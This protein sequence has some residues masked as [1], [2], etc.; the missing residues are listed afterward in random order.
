[1]M[2]QDKQFIVPLGPFNDKVDSHDLRREWEEWHRAFELILQMGK[3]KS[4]SRKLVSMLAMGGRGLQRIYYNLRAVP[5]EV[6]P[7]PIKVPMMPTEIPEYDNAVKRLQHFF[8]GK[9]NE[10][11]DLEVFRSLR[12]LPEE[13]FNTFML[14]LR[15]QAARCEFSEREEKELLQ[16]ITIGAREEKV[17]DKA[18]ENIMNLDEIIIYAMNRE[19]LLQQ[20]EKHKPFS[21]GTEVNS[22]NPS[23]SRNRNFSSSR[24]IERYQRYG[25][26][27][28]DNL[29]NGRYYGA[30]V[31]GCKRCG[32]SR[33]FEDSRDCVARN[34]RCN[35]CGGHGHYAR[36][37]DNRVKQTNRFFGRD[38]NRE[39][40][41]E[42]SR[43]LKS[44]T[45]TVDVAVT[46]EEKDHIA[47]V[48]AINYN[49]DSVLC[50]IDDV[51][52]EFIIDSGS[53]INA[54]TE[55]VWHK[56]ISH[57]AKIFKRK[58]QCDRKF[59]AYANSE[60]LMVTAIFEAL[61]SVNPTKPTNYAEFFVIKGAGKCLLSKRTSEDLKL[62]R[63]GL[64]VLQVNP[65]LGKDT[66][67]FPK[68]PGVQVKLS[69]DPN[70]PPKKIAY[71]RIPAAMEQKVDNKIKEMLQSDVIEK[72][73]GPAD[74]ISPMV[75]VPKGKDDIRICI[76]MKHP[77]E[78]IQ[79]EHYPLPIIDTFLNK[80]K[81]SKFYSRLDITSAYHHVELHPDSRG[82]TTFMTNMG[83]MRF[84]R[85][86][87]GINCA[88]EIFQRIMTDM[89]SG[90]DGVIVY[91]DDIV[92]SGSNREE[93]DKRLQQVL[94]VL[95][96]NNAM[97]NR[98]KFVF[99]VEKL[100]ILGFE[101]SAQGISPSEEK[102][103]AIKNFR[104]PSSK[105]EVRSFLGLLNFVGHFIP[106][107]STRT[108]PLRKFI[109]GEVEMF[110]REQMDAFDDLRLELSNNVRELGFYDPLDATAVYVDASPVG[111]GAVLTQTDRHTNKPRI[112]CFA[113]KGLTAAERVYPQTQREALAVV[114]A[115]EKLYLY[116]FGTRFTI[117]TD[118][119]TLE[120]IY[121]GKHQN[122]RRACS[123]A[124]GWALRLQPYDFEIKYIPGA[125]NIADILSR[126][127]SE[128]G[129]Q[130]DETSDHFLFSLHEGFSAITLDE[131]RQETT[132]DEILLAVMSALDTKHWPPEL[133]RYQAFEKELTV[134]DG[135]VVR[136]DR[137]VL[138][139][140]LRTRAL[141]IAHRGHPGIVAMR[142]NIREKMWWPCMDR[143][144]TNAVQEC[145]GCAAVSKEYPPEP[146]IRKEMPERAWQ[147]IAID[148]FSAKECSTFL[149]IV[150]YYSR[151]LKVIEMKNTKAAKT[152]EALESVFHEQTY[153]ETIRSD[154]G[155]PFTSE[156]FSQYCKTKNIRLV[157]T[158]PYWP[159]MNGLVERQNQGVLRALRIAK[160]TGSD[161]RKAVE[162]YVYMY[163]TTPHSV[164]EKASLELMTGRPVKDLLPS[165]RTDP[166]W[167]RD[168]EVRE[169]DA[170]KKMQGKLYTDNRRQAK[171]ADINV[172]DTV[173]LRN[174]ETGKLEPKFRL[175]KFKVLKKIG[176]DTI[177][178]NE[179]GITYR[180]S[181]THL[182]KFPLPSADCA[183]SAHSG[184]IPRD[185]SENDPVSKEQKLQEN[186]R[187][188]EVDQDQVLAKRPIRE[189]RVPLKFL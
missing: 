5:G 175:E 130:F 98:S 113:S 86:M 63:I 112:I 125:T 1:M 120:Y 79:R 154:N 181:V 109:R 104:P 54:V 87:F 108:E 134:I 58:Y 172:G 4:Q 177:V 136:D 96:E 43:G 53:S 44:N 149:V 82:V 115:V 68:F 89:L 19:I 75:V 118:H 144:V 14:R 119:K 147:E 150:D 171:H 22:I 170:I 187:K 16:Q 2:N 101:V 85:L 60:P 31:H 121:G 100:E 74:W 189:K 27:R 24:G 131:I 145:A 111:L 128:P 110:D 168:E 34:A 7:K 173:M 185:N 166:H 42:F 76:N 57:K 178:A 11:V 152:I 32:S 169:K 132:E 157:R 39:Y 106:N 180:R 95:E 155:P 102:V 65:A 123:R 142:R 141:K 176:S 62:L 127:V 3:K 38:R 124:E 83:L 73:E 167:S 30:S 46:S 56:L 8:M 72:V 50:M 182:R 165:L 6:V 41:R 160:A 179:E 116:L 133:F 45:N 18:L 13:S 94:R 140:K 90:I 17:R 29:G 97:L 161:W 36:K 163:N 188:R 49:N 67:P 146:M 107:L 78:A 71:L 70:I 52:V 164:T 28:Q 15:A 25:R 126:L 92:V 114:W 9:R 21:A 137:V 105:E 99:G 186:K 158:I 91:I 103:A 129:K 51:P 35:N 12:Q 159:Q 93:H 88:P 153:P 64:D 139:A 138:P 117:F 66:K 148:F 135:I 48:E 162:D 33:H 184:S 69:I 80:L 37:C 151:F 20:R 26:T 77:N 84:K 61:I 122:G 55:E 10:R 156:E 40:G 143:D 183:A 47:K 174:F 81:H 23:R 59:Y